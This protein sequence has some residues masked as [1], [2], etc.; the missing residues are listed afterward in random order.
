MIQNLQVYKLGDIAEVIRGVTFSSTDGQSIQSEGY[1]PVLRAGNIQDRLILETDLV[2]VPQS[3][4]SKKQFIK[5][6]DIVMCTSS[7]SATVVGKCAISETDWEGSFGAFCVG[8]RPRQIKCVPN[9]LLHYLHSHAFTNWSKNSS[10]ANI[11]NIRKSELEDF[12]IPLPPLSEQ[13]RIAVILDKADGIRRKRQ[14]AIKLA[15][16]FL[17]ATFLYIFGDP[18]SNP[19]SWKRST[20]GQLIKVKSGNFLS[21]TNM[22][23]GNI[24]VYGGNGITGYH[25]EYMFE[26]SLIVIGRVGAYCGAVHKT[27]KQSWITDNALYVAEKSDLISELYLEWSLKM[28]NLN[29]Y[30]SQAGQPLISGGRIYPIEINI[31]PVKLQEKFEN[32]ESVIT[33][34]KQRFLKLLVDSEK[35]FS[36]ITQRAFRGEI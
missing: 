6:N 21:A 7:G 5:Q 34:V 29:Q 2:W 15:D 30:S 13:K 35:V 17:R 12:P 31:P 11:K 1:S 27:E 19:K 25:D 32:L 33:S 9:Y 28:A 16:D 10:G 8:I 3:K 26:K 36:S 20:L 22:R 24:P 23:Q 18:V 4:I 14:F